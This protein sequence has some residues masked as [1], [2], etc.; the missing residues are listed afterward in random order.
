MMKVI[1]YDGHHTVNFLF[2]TDLLTQLST[3]QAYI[4]SFNQIGINDIESVGGKNDSWR[5]VQ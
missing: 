2:T 3:M 5:N 4:R 1:N